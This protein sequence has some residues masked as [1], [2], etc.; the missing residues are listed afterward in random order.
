MKKILSYALLST[1]FSIFSLNAAEQERP[2]P[3]EH[4]R[5]AQQRGILSLEQFKE[6]LR[7]GR[8]PREM[9]LSEVYRQS[10]QM[11]QRGTTYSVDWFRAAPSLQAMQGV[12]EVYTDFQK[13]H[14]L[15][16]YPAYAVYHPIRQSLEATRASF[17]PTLERY[18]ADA[19]R[20]FLAN[21]NPESRLKAM[22]SM[23]T[24]YQDSLAVGLMLTKQASPLLHVMTSD[25]PACETAIREGKTEAI[26]VFEEEL[27]N[28]PNVAPA[29]LGAIGGADSLKRLRR[30]IFESYRG[31]YQRAHQAFL[32]GRDQSARRQEE[33]A[34]MVEL[35]SAI[36]SLGH[37]IS[38]V[39]TG[40][41]GRNE[42]SF[43]KWL[44]DN[45]LLHVSEIRTPGL[46]QRALRTVRAV[47]EHVERA[48]A[49]EELN[50]WDLERAFHYA[51]N[52]SFLGK[53]IHL[54]KRPM[55]D[56][57]RYLSI[58]V[59]DATIEGISRDVTASH[60]L[61]KL[62]DSVRLNWAQLI[63]DREDF[64][65]DSSRAYGLLDSV[66]RNGRVRSITIP[67][68]M[69]VLIHVRGV[70][71]AGC[72]DPESLAENLFRQYE[73][74]RKEVTDHEPKR[75]RTPIRSKEMLPYESAGSGIAKEWAAS[76]RSAFK[77]LAEAE[78]EEESVS[79]R[80]A[81]VPAFHREKRR[82]SVS[83]DTLNDLPEV[84]QEAAPA[85]GGEAPGLGLFVPSGI[86]SV[87][88]LPEERL[89][90][91]RDLTG[92]APL[93]I[94]ESEEDSQ[95]YRTVVADSSAA[96]LPVTTGAAPEPTTPARVARDGV[97]HPSPTLDARR[98]AYAKRLH[99][100]LKERG[101]LNRR[102]RVLRA[103]NDPAVARR[104]NFPERSEPVT[105]H[106]VNY[107]CTH[108]KG[109]K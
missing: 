88:H 43:F 83:V 75:R 63:C 53:T 86:Q 27:A 15:D 102:Q 72:D 93:S 108:Y 59:D 62:R 55:I 74:S 65:E 34:R 22:R 35:A 78:E 41:R 89:A 101:E 32:G 85:D 11:L 103:L 47:G 70:H 109:D 39:F 67:L 82:R 56:A 3:I 105:R 97:A 24:I 6:F 14:S 31:R 60:S 10:W 95:E 5:A 96:S 84:E 87:S 17:V 28:T 69:A 68:Y 58:S 51:R 107:A 13:L 37:T 81:D 20:E 12:N 50:A 80:A 42:A 45:E 54:E 94:E 71:P 2:N 92:P 1:V 52:L 57:L 106:Q 40:L 29:I 16:R 33:A 44:A 36:A 49:A 26:Q 73:A 104:E 64:S 91:R 18:F 30:R 23:H 46:S 38:P 76:L 48:I 77:A 9:R 100:K 21:E 19:F 7:C 61:L 8:Y 25:M 99:Q 98:V 90:Q 4:E 79:E 66:K